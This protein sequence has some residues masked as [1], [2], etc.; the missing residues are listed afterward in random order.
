V[1]RALLMATGRSD[2]AERIIR[3]AGCSHPRLP[4]EPS[5]YAAWFAWA[6]RKA[7][8]HKQEPCPRCGLWVLWKQKR[9]LPEHTPAPDAPDGA[10]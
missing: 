9:S 10:A 1:S 2:V 3:E 4:G 8:T 7:K 6:E 5:G